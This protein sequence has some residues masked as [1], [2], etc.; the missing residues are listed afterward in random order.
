MLRHFLGEPDAAIEAKI[1]A[2]LRRT[3]EAHGG[4]PLLRG[5]PAERFGQRQGLCRRF[6]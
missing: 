4:W 1:G 5:G 6:G 2:Y 3:Q